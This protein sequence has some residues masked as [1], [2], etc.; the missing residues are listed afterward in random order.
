MH[1]A[2]TSS[3]LSCRLP[4][5]C[6]YLGLPVADY[7]KQW[8]NLKKVRVCGPL[9]A[10]PALLCSDPLFSLIAFSLCFLFLFSQLLSILLPG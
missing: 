10:S 6:Q 4:D 7:F 2:N 1:V 8:I 5:Q 3:S 9:G